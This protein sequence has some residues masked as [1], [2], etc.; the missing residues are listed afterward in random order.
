MDDLRRHSAA[1][2]RVLISRSE[3]TSIDLVNQPCSGQAQRY[4]AAFATHRGS[5]VVETWEAEIPTEV[6]VA[7]FRKLDRARIP[8]RGKSDLGVDGTGYTVAF[9][10]DYGSRFS[11]WGTVPEGWEILAEIVQTLDRSSGRY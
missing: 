9:G 4:V 7:L 3:V 5:E 10:D 1:L 6:V 11:W 2:V 8:V